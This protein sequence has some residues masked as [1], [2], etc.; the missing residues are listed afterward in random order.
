M[1]IPLK[2]K[3]GALRGLATDIPE[4]IGKRVICMCG[5]CQAYT[6]FLGCTQEVLDKNG[7]TEVVPMR[8]AHLKITHGLEN[9][10]CVRLSSDG[11][12]RWYAGCCKMPIANTL[13]SSK[14]P[15]AG[16]VHTILD[17][18]DLPRAAAR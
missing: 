13:T 15:F 10:K 6:H 8:P 3:C 2:C 9:L 17:F 16:V 5:D 18:S 12:M 14:I 4:S 1:N 7:G 11:M